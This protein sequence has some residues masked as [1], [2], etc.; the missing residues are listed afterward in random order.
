ME[1]KLAI[2]GFGIVGREFARL[3]QRKSD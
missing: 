1:Y 2:L 3:L